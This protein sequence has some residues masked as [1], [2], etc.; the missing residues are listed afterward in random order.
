MMT[1]KPILKL[2]AEYGCDPL[3]I[4]VNPYN[5]NR[6][7]FNDNKTKILRPNLYLKFKEELAISFCYSNEKNDEKT[8]EE[9]LLNFSKRT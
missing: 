8:D 1:E 3:W 6:T 5:V 7:Q 2:M 9:I 4:D